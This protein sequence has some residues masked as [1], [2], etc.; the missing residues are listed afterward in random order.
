MSNV[1][2]HVLFIECWKKSFWTL[3]INYVSKSVS[4]ANDSILYFFSSELSDSKSFI[5]NNQRG[6]KESLLVL[7][8]TLLFGALVI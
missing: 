6:R 2:F 1:L 5:S 8:I 7:R 4:L 3:F